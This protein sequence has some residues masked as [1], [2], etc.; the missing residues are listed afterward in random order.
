MHL[1][2]MQNPR[3]LTCTSRNLMVLSSMS[4]LSSRAENSHLHPP[5]LVVVQIMTREEA[6]FLEINTVGHP[7]G[8]VVHQEATADRT[9][10]E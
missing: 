7:P 5:L 1:K 6:Q 8:E 3:L 2:L 9:E 4:Q 10:E